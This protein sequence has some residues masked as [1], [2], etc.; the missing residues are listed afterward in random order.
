VFEE[1]GKRGIKNRINRTH[2]LC[3]GCRKPIL[4]ILKKGRYIEWMAL[5]K[6]KQQGSLTKAAHN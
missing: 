1:L 6:R 5:G 2:H 4:A 3:F